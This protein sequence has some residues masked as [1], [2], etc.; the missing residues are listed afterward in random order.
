MFDPTPA[1]LAPAP[2]ETLLLRLYSKRAIWGFSI[3]FTTIFGGVLLYH[4]LRDT[5]RRREA[6]QVLL[7]SVVY[8][9]LAIWALNLL[10]HRSTALT[11]L[12]NAAGGGFLTEY[13]FR[14][15]MPAQFTPKKIWK[16]L[17]ISLLILM[18]FLA[19][20]LYGGP[21]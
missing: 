18:P 4:N 12:V 13:F 21:Q 7:F 20:L 3:A 17:L 14:K 16:A 1:L 5:G 10:P 9:V 11:Y 8:T 6:G 19:A 15:Y 2:A